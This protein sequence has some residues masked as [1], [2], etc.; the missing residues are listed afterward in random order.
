VCVCPKRLAYIA[1][2]DERLEDA[3]E[4]LEAWYPVTERNRDYRRMAFF[5]RDYAELEF[6]RG[7]HATAR[8]WADKALKRFKDLNMLIRAC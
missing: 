7:N 3:E 6:K 4:L 1:V 2:Q 5:E 8:V